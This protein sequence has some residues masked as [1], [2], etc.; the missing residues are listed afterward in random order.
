LRWIVANRQ[1]T[2]VAQIDPATLAVSRQRSMPYGEDRT[3]KPAGWKG[4][5]G[6][7]CGTSD[8]TGLTHLGAPE[9]DPTMGR[10]VSGDPLM[11]LSDPQQWHA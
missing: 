6:Y 11:D 5:K 7:A 10:F 9:Y 4:N 3:A 2:G 8:D 1:G